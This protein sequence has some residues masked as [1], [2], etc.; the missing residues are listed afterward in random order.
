MTFKANMEDEKRSFKLTLSS[1]SI[2]CDVTN[3]GYMFKVN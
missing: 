1:R 2:V 3:R